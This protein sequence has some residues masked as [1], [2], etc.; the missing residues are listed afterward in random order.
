MAKYKVLHPTIPM[1]EE[2]AAIMHNLRLAEKKFN[3]VFGHEN[4][5]KV[6]YWQEKADLWLA[7]NVKKEEEQP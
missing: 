6:K 2:L 5:Q 3:D 1:L 7:N 4:R